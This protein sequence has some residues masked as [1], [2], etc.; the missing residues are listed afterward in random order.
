MT[1]QETFLLCP[2]M[3]ARPLQNFFKILPVDFAFCWWHLC[4][5][6]N[7][8][9]SKIS[10]NFPFCHYQMFS[11]STRKMRDCK[12]SNIII[13]VCVVQLENLF[14]PIAANTSGFHRSGRNMS[15]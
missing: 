4:K 13:K 2:T 1:K 12:K 9:K 14:K 15:G 6:L 11:K 10:L 3:V 8:H 7:I 5:F